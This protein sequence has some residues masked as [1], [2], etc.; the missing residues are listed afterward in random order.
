MQFQISSPT[1]V[2]SAD[3]SDITPEQQAI[4]DS[5]E[6]SYL[7][8]VTKVFTEDDCIKYLDRDVIEKG[9]QPVQI[10]IKNKSSKAFYVS[11][12]RIDMPLAAVAQVARS[13]HTSTAKRVG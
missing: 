1:L 5:S 11:P 7:Q 13:V 3:V 6:N 2:A 8:M 10:M 12:D 4:I 9:Y